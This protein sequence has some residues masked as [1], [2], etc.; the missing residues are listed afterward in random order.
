MIDNLESKIEPAL[1]L[2]DLHRYEHPDIPNFYLIRKM[3][4]DFLSEL[5]KFQTNA[6]RRLC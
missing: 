1:V 6:L 4:S 5:L 3:E 2:K